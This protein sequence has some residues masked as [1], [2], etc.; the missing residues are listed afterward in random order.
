M[1][2]FE[3]ECLLTEATEQY[4]TVQAAEL[5]RNAP[6]AAPS[7]AYLSW[8]RAFLSNPMGYAKRNLRPLWRRALNTAASIALVVVLSLGMLLTVNP[9]ARAIAIRIWVQAQETFTKIVFSGQAQGIADWAPGYVPEGFALEEC[10]LG[11][12]EGFRLYEDAAG[13]RISLEFFSLSAHNQLFFDT[14]HHVYSEK[15]VNGRE[16][17]IYTSTSP[18]F[19]HHVLLVAEH[20]NTVLHLSSRIDCAE[21]IKMAQSLEKQGK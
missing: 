4:A 9:E 6:E 11:A 7:E 21:L 16:L 12:E 13:Q 14:E 3:F 15:D 17:R 5:L 8:E 1:T 2:D 20:E 18:E 10:E 19:S